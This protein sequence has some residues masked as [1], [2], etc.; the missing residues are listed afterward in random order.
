MSPPASNS[1]M[2]AP[3]RMQFAMASLPCRGIYWFVVPSPHDGRKESEFQL[4][5][6]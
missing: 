2:V 3:Q 6:K 4:E 1:P 5:Q